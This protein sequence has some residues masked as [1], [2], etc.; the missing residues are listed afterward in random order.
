[1]KIHASTIQT[2]VLVSL[3]LLG[4]GCGPKPEEEPRPEDTICT[5]DGQEPT[6]TRRCCSGRL[7]AR[8]L[9][10]SQA[11]PPPCA[12][13]GERP[14]RGQDCCDGVP[15]TEGVCGPDAPPR[16]QP[17]LEITS[18]AVTAYKPLNRT[19]WGALC[20]NKKPDG[21]AENKGQFVEVHNKGDADAGGHDLLLGVANTG[22]R[23]IY[24]CT[25]AARSQG[26]RAGST[27]RFTGPYCCVFDGAKLPVGDYRFALVVDPAREVD[28]ADRADNVRILSIGFSLGAGVQG[29][30]ERAVDVIDATTAPRS[31]AAELPLWGSD[32]QDAASHLPASTH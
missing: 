24:G 21:T 12:K 22:S 11:A 5:P 10:T 13:D 14:M 32:I 9:C 16:G 17:D 29:A 4:L 31:A 19:D 8:N 18:V 15:N 25:N 3:L 26:I 27:A 6:M 2:V 23:Q 20:V 28:D 7:G 30:G 1:M